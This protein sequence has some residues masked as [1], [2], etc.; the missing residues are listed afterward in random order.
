M[1]DSPRSVTILGGGLA[2]LSA[3]QRF[4][5]QA[6]VTVIERGPR[7]A[8]PVLRAGGFTTTTAPPALQQP[9]GAER[10]LRLSS[11]TDYRERLAHLHAR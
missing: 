2:G 3:A 9:R 4:V 1:N 7:Q 11:R 6:G 5:E 10:P 8:W